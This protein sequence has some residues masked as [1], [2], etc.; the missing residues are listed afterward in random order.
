[1]I[2]EEAAKYFFGGP[3]QAIGQRFTR[4]LR[5]DAAN[6]YEVIGVVSDAKY[7]Q[8]RGPF[9]R[10]GYV[11]F[12]A[13]PGVLHGLYFHVRTSADPLTLANSVRGAVQSIDPSLAVIDMNTMTVQIDESLWQER[14]FARL[15]TAF[16][17]LALLL[18]CIGLY[19]TISY[20]VGR[21]RS[22]IA[23]RMALGARYTQVLWMVLRQAV[24]LAIAGVVVGV[25]LSLWVGKYVASM[26]FGLTPRDPVTLAF[27]AVVL[28]AIASLA[29]YL[30]ARRAALVDPARALKSD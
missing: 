2:T 17:G 5:Y 27:T 3:A 10:T 6:D 23:V 29:G 15:T 24:L 8:V 22:E 19:G 12:T 4:G 14:L 21:R 9:P 30:P 7:S 13:S 1:V 11:P 16:G 26:L 28:I 18:A 20:G 25:P